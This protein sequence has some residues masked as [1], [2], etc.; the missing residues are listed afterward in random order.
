MV[1]FVV[2]PHLVMKF[3]ASQE[4]WDSH[5]HTYTHAHL[6]LGAAVCR[7]AADVFI[8]E[9]YCSSEGCCLFS[10]QRAEIILKVAT[11]AGIFTSCSL[12]PNICLRPSLFYFIFSRLIV[13]CLALAGS[14][15]CSFKHFS[16]SLCRF[17]WCTLNAA[18]NRQI[19]IKINK[20]FLFRLL[21]KKESEFNDQAGTVTSEH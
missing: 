15:H 8:W 7:S 17:L 1:I 5:T 3:E 19:L 9:C 13:V 21:H 4:E 6:R 2:Q 14:W 20:V 18:V 10:G 11:A 16:L 12:M